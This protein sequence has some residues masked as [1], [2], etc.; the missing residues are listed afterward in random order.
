MPLAHDVVM[1]R[2]V[3]R[4]EELIGMKP[5]R[6]NQLRGADLAELESELA[7]YA[8]LPYLEQ[9]K[10]DKEL[11][12]FAEFIFAQAPDRNPVSGR[13]SVQFRLRYNKPPAEAKK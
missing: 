8:G 6:L 11:S 5:K 7:L 12:R 3:D 4:G 13:I 1:K 2:V 10:A 9:L